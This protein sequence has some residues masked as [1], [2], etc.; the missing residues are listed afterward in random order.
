MR[1]GSCDWLFANRISAARAPNFRT[2]QAVNSS[3]EARAPRP[4]GTRSRAK[5]LVLCQRF[6]FPL[7]S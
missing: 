5:A 2:R 6:R 1:E 3:M 7:Q 4:C